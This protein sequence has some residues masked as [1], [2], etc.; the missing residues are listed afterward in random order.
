MS[1]TRIKQR[2][3]SNTINFTD[4]DA[5]LR[6]EGAKTHQRPKVK[7]ADKIYSILFS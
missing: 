1:I 4:E 2:K 3:K 6:N 5:E 7:K